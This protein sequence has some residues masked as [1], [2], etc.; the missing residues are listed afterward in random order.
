MFGHF[1]VSAL[2][3]LVSISVLFILLKQNRHLKKLTMDLDIGGIIY[4]G[5]VAVYSI[6]LAFVVVIV[7]EQYQNTGDRVQEESSKVFNLYRASYAFP[8]STSG[9]KIRSTVI[10]YVTSV[11]EDEFPAME[12]DSTS[13]ITQ[14]KYNKVW[15]MVYG[16]RPVTDNEKV[17]YASMVESVNQFG[18]ARIIRISDLDPSIPTLMWEIMLAGGLIIIVFAMLFKS[19]HFW[20]H[21]LKI[22]FFSIVIVFNILLIYLLDHPYKGALKIEPTAFTKILNHYKDEK[23]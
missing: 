20:L 22:L 17:W 9:K 11:V 1:Y 7:W 10:D 5:I 2:I 4:G 13:K 16:I 23:K 6:L 18:E 12:H 8:D 19:N 15:D 21:F 14:Q 3:F